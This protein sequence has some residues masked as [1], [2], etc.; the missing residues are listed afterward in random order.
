MEYAVSVGQPCDNGCEVNLLSHNV[1]V[2]LKGAIILVGQLEHDT[3]LWRVNITASHPDPR[4]T[5]QSMYHVYEQRSIDDSSAYLHAACFS[6][7]KDTWLNVIE[8]GNFVGWPGLTTDRVRKYLHKSD[9]TVKGHLNQQWQNT[10]S[11][12]EK[13]PQVDP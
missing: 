11:T 9:A 6:P 3:H 10:R 2:K 8:A 1:G 12:Q 4:P 7:T 5:P 13:E